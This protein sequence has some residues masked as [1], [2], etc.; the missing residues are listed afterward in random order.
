M[1]LSHVHA[2]AFFFEILFLHLRVCLEG[3]DVFL[4][5]RCRPGC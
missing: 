4:C 1:G 2:L 3:T 5:L